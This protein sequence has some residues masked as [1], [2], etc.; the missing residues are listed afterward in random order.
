MPEQALSTFNGEPANG[1]WTLLVE[2]NFPAFDDGVFN[3]WGLGV[4]SASSSS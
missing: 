3:Y 1:T 4:C 2:D